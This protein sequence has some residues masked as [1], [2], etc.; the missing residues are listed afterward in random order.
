MKIYVHLLSEFAN[1]FSSLHLFTSRR[2]HP[3][4]DSHCQ[5]AF[6]HGALILSS[7]TNDYSRK[8]SS[9]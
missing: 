9:I 7:Q 8:V 1:P 6:N 4:S 3:N 5:G 2:F